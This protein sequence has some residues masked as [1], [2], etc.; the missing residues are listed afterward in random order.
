[1]IVCFFV[2]RELAQAGDQTGQIALEE[3][4]RIKSNLPNCT[5]YEPGGIRTF[6]GEDPLSRSE[7][8]I[9]FLARSNRLLEDPKKSQSLIAII[10]AFGASLKVLRNVAAIGA[11]QLH[12]FQ[13]LGT[14]LACRNEQIKR[15]GG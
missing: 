10:F 11:E 7:E 8:E 9:Y 2:E 14:Q 5:F 15:S 6:F 1:M 3:A 4:I 12:D 13:L